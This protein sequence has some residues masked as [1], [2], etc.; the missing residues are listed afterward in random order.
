MSVCFGTLNGISLTSAFHPKLAVRLRPEA[1]TRYDAVAEFVGMMSLSA[2]RMRYKC[3]APYI[4][5]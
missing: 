3:S 5:T 1:D 2:R 4:V